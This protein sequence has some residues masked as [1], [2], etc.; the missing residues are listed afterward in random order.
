MSDGN[1]GG[2]EYSKSKKGWREADSSDDESE[3][4]E[5]LFPPRFKVDGR[6]ACILCSGET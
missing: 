1:E 5:I 4:D 3:G 6:E 2:N